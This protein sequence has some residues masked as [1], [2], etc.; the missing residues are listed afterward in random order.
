MSKWSGRHFGYNL[1]VLILLIEILIMPEEESIVE[2][3]KSDCLSCRLIRGL[4]CASAGVYLIW[5]GT[6]VKG[7]HRGSVLVFGGCRYCL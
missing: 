7:Y 3:K 2:N 6:Q 5:Q 1:P 4:G